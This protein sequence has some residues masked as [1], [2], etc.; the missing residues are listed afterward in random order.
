MKHL[1]LTL[2]IFVSLQS[3]HA[4]WGWYCDFDMVCQELFIDTVS[5]PDNIWEVG[6][7]DKT[8]FDIAHS[9]TQALITDLNDPYPVN[10]TSYLLFE[11]TS[12]GGYEYSHTAYISGYYWV[13]SDSL[14]DYGTMEISLDQGDTW[15]DML[16]DTTYNSGIYWYEN[17]KP[18]LTGNSGGWKFFR[19]SSTYL[20]QY[21]T[22]NSGDTVLYRFGFVSDGQSD[23]LD[24]L[25]Y[26][27]F[28][29][30]DYVENLPQHSIGQFQSKVYP[31][32]VVKEVSISFSN[33]RAQES[34]CV[35]VDAYGRIVREP[36]MTSTEHFHF[37]L[38]D[39]E[40]GIYYYRIQM[41]DE[42]SKGKVVVE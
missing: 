33:P 23:T 37:D 41:G 36:K 18:V 7:P 13:N 15:I 20:S 29:V 1:F 24:G 6:V 27:S 30:E 35:I 4:Q 34:S 14:N 28:Q 8:V 16:D 12:D 19:Y 22:V 26:D 17:K 5:N 31:N 21:F 38:Q 25:M 10:D 3:I 9:N 42:V 39:M 40:S 32:P 2:L 11:Y